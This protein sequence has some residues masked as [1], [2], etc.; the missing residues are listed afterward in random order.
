MYLGKYTDKRI[1][2]TYLSIARCYQNAEGKTRTKV[3]QY[4]GSLDELQKQFDDPIA[5][6]KDNIQ[7]YIYEHIQE[8]YKPNNECVFYDVTNYYFEI[9]DSDELREKGVCKDNYPPV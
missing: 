8:Q 2:K 5:H 6:F 4:L 9:D 3:I 1:N 7:K